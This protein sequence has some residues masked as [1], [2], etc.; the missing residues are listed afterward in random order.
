MWGLAAAVDAERGIA[1]LPIAGPA[2]N[3]YG[4]DRPGA[5][6]FGNSIVAVDVMTGKYLWHFQTVHHD[7]WDIDMPATGALITVTQNGRKTPAIA[8]VGKNSYFFVLNRQDGKPLIPVE[9]RAVPKGD[10]PTEWYSPTQPFPVRPGPLSPTS[11]K[12]DTDMVR[13]EDTTPEHAA[14]CQ[15]MWDD[16]G[17]YINLG[18]Y[19]PFMY[20]EDGKP[21]RSTIQ[22]PGGTGGVNWGGVAS[23]PENGIVFANAQTASLV[24]W[25]EKVPLVKDPATGKD[26]QAQPYYPD[27]TGA[28]QVSN[29]PYNRA[30]VTAKG[31]FSSFTA[32]GMPCIRPPWAQLVAVNANTGEILWKSVLGLNTRLPEGKQLVGG[33]GSAGPTATAGGLVFVGATGDAR[34][35]AFDAKTGK[36]LW[37]KPLNAQGNAN[38]MTYT[39]KN[40]KQYVAISAGGTVNV[41]ALP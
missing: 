20:H 39:A 3:Y 16:A 11:F 35:R 8:E 40:G 31:P 33:S 22:L 25:V 14:A 1:Y 32:M 28:G 2:A 5:N 37:E 7:L 24:G 19:T 38:P 4:G 36:Q 21:P 13:P 17:G 27:S 30:S 6:L 29:Q 12:K 41:F 34:F 10:V 15:K 23:D 9:E 26:V 18:P